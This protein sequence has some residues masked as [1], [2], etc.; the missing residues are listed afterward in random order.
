MAVHQGWSRRTRLFTLL[1]CAFIS[2]SQIVVRAGNVALTD[3]GSTVTIAN[4][5]VS[6]VVQKSDGKVTTFNRIGG[7]NLVG[8]T[9]GSGMYF[10]ANVTVGTNSLY[11]GLSPA[12]YSVVT[13]TAARVE[14]MCRNTNFAQ[15]GGWTVGG[16]DVELHF[17]MDS[18]SD[19]FYSYNVWRHGAGQPGVKL[20]QTRTVTR[21]DPDLF[22]SSAGVTRYAYSSQNN[23]GQMR[24]VI[25]GENPQQITDATTEFPPGTYYTNAVGS[26]YNGMPVYSKY[27]WADLLENHTAHGL[28]SET[29]G[30]WLIFASMEYYNGGPTKGVLLDHWATNPLMIN[31]FQGGHFGGSSITIATNE[32]WEKCYGPY[33]VYANA[34]ASHDQLWQDAQNRA[35]TEKAAWPYSWVNSPAYPTQ[36]GRVTGGL[37]ISGQ[38]TSNALL[39]LAQPGSYWQSQSRDY[40]FWTRANSNGQFTIPAVRPG[41][42]SLFARVPGV[43]GEYELTN[44]IVTA[45]QTNNLGTL[46]WTPTKYQQTLWRIGTPD[47]TTGGFRFADRKRQ[48]G[49]WF[50]YLEERGT[51]DLDFVVGPSVPSNDWYYAQCVIPLGAAADTNGIYVAPKWNVIFTLTNTP[52]QPAVSAITKN[53]PARVELNRPLPPT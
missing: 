5:L 13:N 44:V 45:N 26:N 22:A 28:A 16:F 34:G 21:T 24:G 20:E 51:N 31:E 32:V 25:P 30:I 35:A 48:F 6:M 41:A 50:R 49:L 38:S 11:T 8:N 23:F 52:P 3:N 27:D 37:T 40:I 29:N 42:Y 15:P 14:V 47:L 2:A 46:A 39:V 7:P 33:F 43:F 1:A 12:T 53:R 9:S 36:R 19:G 18:N 4:G 10:D 17:V